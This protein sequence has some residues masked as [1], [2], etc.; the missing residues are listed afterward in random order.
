VTSLTALALACA[1][2]ALLWLTLTLVVLVGRTFHGV[3]RR[4]VRATPTLDVRRGK[5]LARRARHHRTEGGRWRRAGALVELGRASSTR[6]RPPLYRAALRD[7]DTDVR[8]AAVRGLGSL[9]ETAVWARE[10]LVE[11]LVEEYAPRS[12]VAAQLEHL[13]PAVGSFLV[14][15]LDDRRPPVRYWAAI[16]LARYPALATAELQELVRDPDAAVRRA[17]VESLGVRGDVGALDAVLACLDDEVM[18]VRAHAC[19]AAGRLGGVSVA[20]R[21]VPLLGDEMWWV[22][23]GAKDALR[24][25]GRSVGPVLLP[26]LEAGDRFARN[27]AAEVLQDVG[28][29]DELLRLQ[30]EMPLLRRIFEAGEAGLETAAHGRAGTEASRDDAGTGTDADQRPA[31]DREA[32]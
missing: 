9:G 10:L 22:R 5:R 27:G 31:G 8:G 15:L 4:A 17:A 12:R 11:A 21:L 20:G 14:P 29:V 7:G 32:A 30:P 25:M 2:A 23:A 6:A 26:V 16:L 3:R 1:G 19:R 13:A 28:I 24:A 18:F